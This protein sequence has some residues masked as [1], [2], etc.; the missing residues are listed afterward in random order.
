[1]TVSCAD[2]HAAVKCAFS[3]KWID[4][5]T[6]AA[7]D[8]AFNRPEIRSGI[9]AGPIGRGGIA[10]HSQA[11][12]NRGRAGKGGGA[13]GAQLIEGR[14]DL[15]ILDFLLRG[16]NQRGLRLQSV[17]SGNFTGD[18]AQRGYLHIALFGNFFQAGVTILQLLFFGAQLIV[19]RNLQQHAGIRAGDAGEAKESDGG[20]DYENIQIMDGNGDLAQLAVVPAGH[21]KD[22]ETLVQMPSFRC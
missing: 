9:G 11:D 18:R 12:A 3:V 15:G 21:K 20:A 10:S 8:L 1:M 6:E 17:K 19:M 4:A 5:L 16:G 22:V 2:I 14:T 7:G 13:Q